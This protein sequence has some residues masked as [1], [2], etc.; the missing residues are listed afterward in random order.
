[1]SVA[2]EREQPAQGS[3]EGGT[4]GRYR[5]LFRIAAGGMAEVYVGAQRGERGFRKLVA[6]KRML[7]H[8]GTDEH[9]V[10]MFL[11][12]ARIAADI[13]SPYV[14]PTLDL[15]VDENDAPFLVMELVVGLSLAQLLRSVFARGERVPAPIALE[16]LAQAADGLH[17]AHEARSATGVPLGIVHRD[18][19]PQN[20]LVGVDG[21]ARITDFG[22]ARALN[23]LTRTNT[24]E[25]K[26]KFAYF[27]PEQA[28]AGDI[29]A[30]ADVFALG[31]VAWE[32]FAGERLFAT[33]NPLTT[34]EAV[35]GKAIP[36]LDAPPWGCS[37]A[38]ANAVADALE[39]DLSKRFSTATEFSRALRAAMGGARTDRAE[40]EAWL[41]K[42]EGARL[43]ALRQKIEAAIAGFEQE[44]TPSASASGRSSRPSNVE[45][46]LQGET[47][48]SD[49][50]SPRASD[51]SAVHTT[52][53]R[54]HEGGE[55][56][57][58]QVSEP[59]R[60]FRVRTAAIVLGL[61]ALL[62]LGAGAWLLGGRR[63]PEPV[64]DAAAAP[65]SSALPVAAP[66]APVT[67][68]PSATPSANGEA[69]AIATD[70]G[71]VSDNAANALPDAQAPT[72]TAATD[73]A[74]IEGVRAE[75]AADGDPT[76]VRADTTRSERPRPRREASGGTASAASPEP[77]ATPTTTPTTPADDA[78]ANANRRGALRGMDTFEREL[79]HP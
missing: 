50:A 20:V 78:P 55:A 18:I 16:L 61:C 11:D 2:A 29:D 76:T 32:T 72:G 13:A 67:T 74:H 52:V 1:M 73:P 3:A 34:L 75:P 71:A 66:A 9:F 4:L 42:V 26:G 31:V 22:V 24:G 25:L 69:T 56:D 30:R 10:Q 28:S 21:R 46:A 15:G 59:A 17:D 65:P 51:A 45:A 68:P 36:R 40:I 49:A 53:S 39:R 48:T 58:Q 70:A 7:P 62:G 23:R 41:Q 47:G 19:S 33:D 54:P 44:L 8:L 5:L 79:A 57:A 27:S 43:D 64:A 35:R 14:V 63:E 77:A 12:E 38:V 37:K 6:I 60:G